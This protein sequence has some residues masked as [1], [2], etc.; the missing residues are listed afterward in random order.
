MKSKVVLLCVMLGAWSCE[1][2]YPDFGR[3]IP[4]GD[5]SA[6]VIRTTLVSSNT[7]EIVYDTELQFMWKSFGLDNHEV[8]KDHFIPD[9]ATTI[10]DVQPLDYY[11][12]TQ[13]DVIFLIDQSKSYEETDPYNSRSQL[14]NKFVEE[15]EG[16]DLLIG[17]F[18]KNG[19]LTEPIEFL[20]INDED[21]IK[22]V[23]D[24]AKRTGGTSNLYDALGA[25]IESFSTNT[26]NQKNIVALVQSNDESS[27]M[28]L[29][30]LI[31]SA[32]S[33][34]VKIHIIALGNT[35]SHNIMAKLTHLTGGFYSACETD[36]QMIQALHNL[37]RNITGFSSGVR[38]R[39]KVM[40][41][42]GVTPG[43]EFLHSLVAE[44]SY[45]HYNYNPVYPFV[46]IP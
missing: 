32:S 13:S 36:K 9:G 22:S 4:E 25:A 30:N 2:I 46:K 34:N 14:I 43:M 12:T 37:D 33:N 28:S 26:T 18:A 11:G 7:T 29:Q 27:N 15:F 17:G 5:I 35:V 41:P 16:Q 3:F 42:G 10:I 6:L 39:V 8:L 19:E 21:Y 23:I 38:V 24:L 31:A 1:V 44:D 40:P 45:Y 20:D